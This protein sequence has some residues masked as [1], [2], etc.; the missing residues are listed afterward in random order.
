MQNLTTEED[1]RTKFVYEWLRENGIQSSD[2]VLE[3]RVVFQV[4]HGQFETEKKEGRFDLL[5]KSPSGKNL[6][7]FEVKAPKIEVNEAT[8][9]QAIS[10]ARVLKGNM[11]PIVV[12]TNKK[13]FDIY[14]SLTKNK[15]NNLNVAQ[16]KSGKFYYSDNN[17]EVARAEA[18]EFL[19]Q[20]N[21]FIKCV[22]K[23]LSS[24]EINRLSGKLGSLKKYC[25]DLYFS[26]DDK[27]E[28][29]LDILL[30]TGPPQSGKTNY[31]CNAY[32]EVTESNGIGLFFRARSIINGIIP[33][34]KE[35][36]TTHLNSA[37]NASEALTN[38]LISSSNIT[39][40]ID[41]LNEVPRRERDNIISDIER[42]VQLKVSFVISCT[43]SFVYTIKTDLYNNPSDI[44]K[45]SKTNKFFELKIPSLSTQT[46]NNVIAHYQKVYKTTQKPKQRLSSINAVG[47]FY[48]LVDAGHSPMNLDSEYKVLTKILDDK[49]RSIIEIE[50]QDSK[51][52][53]LYLAQEMANNTTKVKETLFSDLLTGKKFALLPDSFKSHGILEVID[54]FVEF[55]DETYRD[56]LLIEHYSENRSREEVIYKLSTLPN[57]DVSFTCLFKY[58][59]FYNIPAPQVFKLELDIQIRM[60]ETIM[61]YIK[62][63]DHTNNHIISLLIDLVINGIEHDLIA[64][65]RA[66][67]VL[68]FIADICIEKIE[69]SVDYA[70]TQYILG[71]CCGTIIQPCSYEFEEHPIGF[72]NGE[73]S[74][75]SMYNYLGKLFFNYLIEGSES[76]FTRN[77]RCEIKL[78]KELYGEKIFSLLEV[79]YSNLVDHIFNYDSGYC[80]YGS[81]LSVEIENYK[82]S[83]SS[84][85]LRYAHEILLELKNLLPNTPVF[86]EMINEI[87]RECAFND[88]LGRK[89]D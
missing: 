29:D 24:S 55:Y 40:F 88:Y 35:N 9:D 25:R 45:K 65:E 18:F 86:D 53:L 4:G 77:Y 34:L 38:K 74:P 89:L 51:S 64:P 42:I 58:L 43:D 57:I 26:L 52:A 13:T 71:Y 66:E 32:Y 85:E 48:Q 75:N 82:E 11:A 1:V 33:Y 70:K 63:R 19:G 69:I 56:I 7:L 67:S 80:H 87:N 54:G 73:F 20:D 3:H 8:I 50:Q 84:E 83:G 31:I 27:P 62:N 60:I 10:Y 17:L 15:I 23:Q 5:V 14:C 61:S 49:C 36:I 68:K 16:T 22:C 41:G 76:I 37:S 44:F 12:V 79:F 78:A 47:K 21:Y 72:Y 30:I 6:I 81:Y 28:L 2:I 59:C 46:Y 39:I